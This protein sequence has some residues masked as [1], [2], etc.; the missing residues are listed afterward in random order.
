MT[1]KFV[2]ELRVSRGI[3]NFSTCCKVDTGV[4]DFI[5]DIC[6]RMNIGILSIRGQDRIVFEATKPC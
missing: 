1:E 4:D 2:P 3:L 6:S 5:C